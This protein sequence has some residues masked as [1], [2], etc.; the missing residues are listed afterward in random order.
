MTPSYKTLV[1]LTVLSF[2][3][4][5]CGCALHP[6]TRPPSLLCSPVSCA[7]TPYSKHLDRQRGKRKIGVT[8]DGEKGF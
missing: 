2:L 4:R 8:D 5:V 6:Y 3:L 7:S 1:D